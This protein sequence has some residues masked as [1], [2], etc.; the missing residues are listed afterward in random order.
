MLWRRIKRIDRGLC[1][2]ERKCGDQHHD[3]ACANKDDGE[4]WLDVRRERSDGKELFQP[5]HHSGN[6]HDYNGRRYAGVHALKSRNSKVFADRHST[7]LNLYSQLQTLSSERDL[8]GIVDVGLHLVR[9][10]VNYCLKI[11]IPFGLYPLYRSDGFFEI[12]Q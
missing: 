7:Y 5:P 8:N 11:V 6:D 4:Q 9:R 2:V 1:L 10:F 12:F 3:D